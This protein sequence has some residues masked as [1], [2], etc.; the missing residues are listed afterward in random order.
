MFSFSQL[1]EVLSDLSD[2]RPSIGRGV[3]A[4]LEPLMAEAFR[5]RSPPR[6]DDPL[7]RWA[8]MN[9][10]P[11]A[12]ENHRRPARQIARPS[13]IGTLIPGQHHLLD[14]DGSHRR[15][16]RVKPSISPAP[17]YRGRCRQRRRRCR[18]W[19]RWN[20]RDCPRSGSRRRSAHTVGRVDIPLLAA[21]RWTRN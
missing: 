19:R 3:L 16:E 1:I 15:H 10:T 7:A 9:R 5:T 8:G 17:R 4:S 18:S 20:C 12:G 14:D 21:C 13:R 6:P 2:Q 11:P